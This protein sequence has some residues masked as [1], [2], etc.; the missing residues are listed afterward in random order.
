[1]E[2]KFYKH[3]ESIV[4]EDDIIDELMEKWNEMIDEPSYHN[5]RALLKKRLNIENDSEIDENVKLKSCYWAE[6]CECI[7]KIIFIFMLLIVIMDKCG[8]RKTWMIILDLNSIDM[9]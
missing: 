7:T 9:N 1:M 8:M 2:R 4:D 6:K 3:L 5:L